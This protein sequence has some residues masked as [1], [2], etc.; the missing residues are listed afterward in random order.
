MNADATASFDRITNISVMMTRR[1]AGILH[2]LWILAMSAVVSACTAAEYEHPWL[3]YR[4]VQEIHGGEW[5]EIPEAR[6][7][8]LAP[9]KLSS[10]I[11][12]IERE[13]V[14]ELSGL[15]AGEFVEGSPAPGYRFFLLRAVRPITPNANISV[16]TDGRSVATEW[17]AL[18]KKRLGLQ[19]EPV[20]VELRNPPEHVFVEVSIAE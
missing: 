15:Q 6:I 11:R 18:T 12:L 7:H 17:G 16:L 14:R 1:P 13:A 20:I 10:A 9:G 5:D 3:H 8:K 4:P 19:R 2:L